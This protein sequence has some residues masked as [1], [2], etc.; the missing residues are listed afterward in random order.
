MHHAPDCF[1]ESELKVIGALDA[2]RLW[3][4]EKLGARFC[5]STW[6]LDEWL[7]NFIMFALG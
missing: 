2:L 3:R 5:V 4:E 1:E 7:S 6:S